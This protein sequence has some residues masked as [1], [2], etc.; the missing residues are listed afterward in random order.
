MKRC[1][2]IVID[3]VY[4][5][6]FIDEEAHDVRR[7]GRRSPLILRRFKTMEHESKQKRCS[8]RSTELINFG[9]SEMRERTT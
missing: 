3:E 1:P 4:F 9:F 2:S 5:G 7:S 8:T 6:L